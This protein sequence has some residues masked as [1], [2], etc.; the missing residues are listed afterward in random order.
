MPHSLLIIFAT[1]ALFESLTI[2]LIN[3]KKMWPFKL[4]EP[5]ISMPHFWT[6][7]TN[8]E[9][10]QLWLF[11]QQ[12]I[13]HFI[14]LLQQKI[15]HFIC[16]LHHSVPPVH[17]IDVL[18]EKICWLF[19]S[20]PLISIFQHTATAQAHLSFSVWCC[21]ISPISCGNIFPADTETRR[22]LWHCTKNM[23]NANVIVGL[24]EELGKR[25]LL[26]LLMSQQKIS[27]PCT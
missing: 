25:P 19:A 1:L 18:A 17:S 27:L 8:L 24:R 6:H 2:F 15:T 20:F 23:N 7:P 3:C 5:W 11:L 9:W 10:G 13:T 26:F 21:R 4:W 16:L 22:G 12:K 14:H